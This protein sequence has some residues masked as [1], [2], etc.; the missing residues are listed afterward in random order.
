VG[1]TGGLYLFNVLKANTAADGPDPGFDQRTGPR[2]ETPEAMPTVNERTAD[3]DAAVIEI[4]GLTKRYG[5]LRA[6]AGLDLRVPRGTIFGFLGP[7]GAGK[8]TTLRILVGLLRATAGR[9]MLFGR[10]AWADST[11][12]RSRLGYLSGDVRLYER[13]TGARFLAFC[14]RMRGGGAAG[15]IQRLRERFNL[16]LD[17]RI[18]DYSRG[19][20]QKLGLIHAMM[21]RPPLLILDEPTVALDPLV[22]QTLYAELRAVAAE[23]RTV[24][25]SSHTLSEVEGLC[26]RVAIIRAGRLVEE[27]AISDL[28][29]RALRRVEFRLRD[30]PSATLRVP[31]GLTVTHTGDH[32]MTASWAGPTDRLIAWLATLDLSD[33]TITAPRLEDLFATY[34]REAQTDDQ[35]PRPDAS[36]SLDRKGGRP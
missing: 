19:M 18:R 24:L 35:E 31:P 27:A 9:A 15:E 8:T 33:V 4:D 26:D 17:R 30:A 12:V 25:F 36:N 6:L 32:T 21:H 28:A 14:D 2:L 23:G 16:N 20:K 7:N 13:M 29:A 3:R 22:R 5:T 10:D 34:Y 11:A 1:A